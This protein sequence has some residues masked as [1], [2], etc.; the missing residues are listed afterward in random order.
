MLSYTALWDSGSVEPWKFCLSVSFF[1]LFP[2][3]HSAFLCLTRSDISQLVVAGFASLVWLVYCV[4]LAVVIL[5]QLPLTCNQHFICWIKKAWRQV[6]LLLHIRLTLRVI[7][8]VIFRNGIYIVL[9]C[10][11]RGCVSQGWNIKLW[12]RPL[13]PSTSVKFASQYWLFGICENLG[14]S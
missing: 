9:P 4:L 8:E 11:M 13:G 10:A 12:V 6:K 14:W 7:P 5:Y 2:Y 1:V 3:K